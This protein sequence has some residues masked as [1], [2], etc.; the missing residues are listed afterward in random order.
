MEQGHFSQLFRSLTGFA[1][2]RWQQQ[3]YD[4]FVE[5]RPPGTLSLPTG[6]GKT[7]LMVVWL[8]ALATARSSVPR[9]LVWV[10]NRRVVVD[11]A[12]AQAEQLRNGLKSLPSLLTPLSHLSARR[13]DEV[14]AISTLRGELADNGEWSIDA[15]RPAIIIGTV[16][17]VGSR[18]LFSGYGDSR[19]M[20]P[21]HAGL[22]GQDTLIVNDEAHLTPAF[23]ELLIQVQQTIQQHNLIRPFWTMRLSATQRGSNPSNLSADLAESSHFRRLWSASKQM[24]LVPTQKAVEN[25]IVRLATESPAPRTVMF[26]RSPETAKTLAERIAKH[27]GSSRVLV[28]SGEM[29]GFERD[30]LALRLQD[31]GFLHATSTAEP[32]WL[33]STSAGEVG[34]NLSCERMITELDTAERLLQRFGRLNRFAEASG[35]AWV[36]FPEGKSF[37][38]NKDRHSRLEATLNYLTSLPSHPRGGFDVSVGAL[39]GH[40]PSL[41][42]CTPAPL[43]AHFHHWLVSLWSQTSIRPPQAPPVEPWLHGKQDYIADTQIAWRQEISFL[44][45]PAVTDDDLNRYVEL[46]PVLAHERLRIPSAR[47]FDRLK[48]NLP[49]ATSLLLVKYSQVSRALLSDLQVRDLAFALLLLP[50]EIA[51]LRDGHLHSS[52]DDSPRDVSHELSDPPLWRCS[53]DDPEGKA[54]HAIPLSNTETLGETPP[55]LYILNERRVK[56]LSAQ[57]PMLDQHTAQVLQ[58]AS[59][60]AEA[61]DLPAEL[62][63]SLDSAARWHDA[64]KA[65]SVWQRFANGPVDGRPLAKVIGTTSP[66]RLAGFRHEFESLRRM[67]SDDDLAA[68]LVASHH[69]YARPSFPESASD[70]NV[71]SASRNLNLESA[72]RYA[73]LSRHFGEWG[74]A[75]LEAVFHTAD[76]LGSLLQEVDQDA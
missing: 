38:R 44:E 69:G 72:R 68:H 67:E 50:P 3:L 13:H 35:V 7:S 2:Y 25:E 62:R 74:L 47:L 1:P 21:R 4:S 23:A 58:A 59:R 54:I 18:L 20:R 63:A 40:P 8:L 53:F 11:Q 16:D 46:C 64:G 31:L 52:W 65:H 75:Y 28:L 33:V 5:G 14:L 45:N 48:N 56:E 17:M 70:K 60:L 37:D 27:T 26:V 57:E 24:H 29:R 76:A 51:G 55:T 30:R 61:L 71:I 36:V 66:R 10:V 6:S 41:E 19:R 34:I 32:S 12:T 42:A 73:R 9:R 22:L 49:P 39:Q 43:L 15:S